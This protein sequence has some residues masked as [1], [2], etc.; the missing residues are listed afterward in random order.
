[1]TTTQSEH[2]TDVSNIDVAIIG[3]GASGLSAGTYTARGGLET[4]IF[5]RGQSAIHQ[6][7]LLENY[8][9]FPAGVS[10]TTFVQIGQAHAAYEGCTVLEKHVEELSQSKSGFSLL[11]TDGTQLE[12]TRVIASSVYDVEYLSA[13]LEESLLDDEMRFVEVDDGGR[14]AIDGLYAAGRLTP[15]AHQAI[16]AAGNGARVGVSVVRDSHRERGYWDEIADYRDWVVPE[17]KYGGEEWDAHVD[18]WVDSTIP[19]DASFD[20]KRVERVRKDV[21]KRRLNRQIAD[22]EKQ[23]RIADNREIL[24]EY[25]NQQ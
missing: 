25:L 4:V 17:G 10:P 3:G 15:I 12:A 19:D 9:G 7:G 1:M 18:A 5:S 14:T 21:K 13:D 23:R 20:P 2:E 24:R 16:I 8:L 22:E 11:T 6:C